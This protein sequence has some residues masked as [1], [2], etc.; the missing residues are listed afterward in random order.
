MASFNPMDYFLE[1]VIEPEVGE[2]APSAGNNDLMGFPFLPWDGAEFDINSCVPQT[3]FYEPPFADAGSQE[4]ACSSSEQEG[5]GRCHQAELFSSSP[6]KSATQPSRS[7]LSERNRRG[8]MKDKLLA[9]RSLVPNITK[10]DK[11]SLIGDATTYVQELQKE[12]TKLSEEISQLERRLQGEEEGGY[13]FDVDIPQKE[14]NREKKSG[15][16]KILQMAVVRTDECEFFVKIICKAAKGI[17]VRVLQVLESL[18]DI[19]IQASNL[20]AVEGHINLTSTIHV[21]NCSKE[22]DEAA[23][24]ISLLTS[25][26]NQGLD[27]PPSF[28]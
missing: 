17:V 18:D 28:R 19:S 2:V 7:L 8:R 20:T 13:E 15:R 16:H 25:F 26:T 9:L 3:P 12:A 5:G 24:K 21:T 11:A 4:I 1:D 27:M 22:I 14:T 10:M 23:L 6:S